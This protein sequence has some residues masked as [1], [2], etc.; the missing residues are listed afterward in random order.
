[1]RHE[2]SGLGLGVLYVCFSSALYFLHLY[3][4][5]HDTLRTSAACSAC[6]VQQFQFLI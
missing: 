5:M 3:V 2:M 6:V 1:M 4:G